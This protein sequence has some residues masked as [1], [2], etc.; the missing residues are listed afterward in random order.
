MFFDGDAGNILFG[1][2]IYSQIASTYNG[3]TKLKF[4]FGFWSHRQTNV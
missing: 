2:L 4:I 3:C 1:I